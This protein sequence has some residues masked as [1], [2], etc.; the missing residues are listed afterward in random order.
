MRRVILGPVSLIAVAV[1]LAT[2]LSSAARPPIV[3]VFLEN[4]SASGVVG[5]P[6]MP[7][8]NSLIAAGTSFTNYREGDATGPSLPDYL[9]LVAGSRC[10]SSSDNVHAGQF[11]APCTTTV[12][13]QLQAAGQSW[14]V[15]MDGMDA[16]CSSKT[17][18]AN[19]ALDTPYALKH[20]PATPFASIFGDK[21]LCTAHVLPF[22]ALPVT[23]PAVSFV[24]PG[25]CNDQHG[26]GGSWTDCKSK[27]AALERRGDSWIQTHI[28]PLIAAG[29]DV[30]ITYDEPKG[31]M[32][33]L[34]AVGVGPAFAAGASSAV[35]Y[36][37][38]SVLAGIED[39]FGL[40]RLNGAAAA[41]PIGFV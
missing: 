8:L 13:N 10:G 19:H 31:S 36:T 35:A 4:H 38:Y 6:N 9:E 27:S 30:F 20:N 40:A 17:T 15:Y 5:N 12:W 26:S 14:G 21:A 34:F 1:A 18:Y 7:Y 23:L 11:G 29:A 3:V 2:S 37:H 16:A 32:S 24:A 22:G 39:A 41:T 28:G 33:T 25:I